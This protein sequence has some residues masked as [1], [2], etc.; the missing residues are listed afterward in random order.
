MANVKRLLVVVDGSVQ[1]NLALDQAIGIA[2]NAPRSEV[3]LL[4][5]LPPIS[6]WQ[7]HRP[8]SR[9]PSQ[10]AQRVTALAVARATS[11]GVPARSRIEAG[12]IADVAARVAREEACGHIFLPEHGPTPVARALKSLTGLSTRTAASRIRSLSNVP[13]TLVVVH[14]RH[15]EA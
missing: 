8:A 6:P 15:G 2:R 11:A 5:V 13:V 4:H 9:P 14:E 1:A 3:L 12:E 10:V 7:V